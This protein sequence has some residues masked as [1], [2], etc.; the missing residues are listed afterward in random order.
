VL[1]EETRE[2]F[3]QEVID[4]A[5]QEINMN[6][7]V[8]LTRCSHVARYRGHSVRVSRC[9]VIE[10]EQGV[11]PKW[12]DPST[13]DRRTVSIYQDFAGYGDLAALIDRHYEKKR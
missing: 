10:H 7:L 4:A 12:K 11:Q 6:R 2:R 9:N 1:G 3:L 13:S 8:E 5:Q